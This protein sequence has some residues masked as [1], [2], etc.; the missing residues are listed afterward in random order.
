MEHL[1]K[2]NLYLEYSPSIPSTADAWQL[3]VS[4]FCPINSL[5]SDWLILFNNPLCR[6]V[7][8]KKWGRKAD[9]RGEERGVIQVGKDESDYGQFEGG[10][11]DSLM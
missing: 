10:R 1:G 9:C 5:T 11:K 6:N 7:S 4:A 8:V 2:D 3:I